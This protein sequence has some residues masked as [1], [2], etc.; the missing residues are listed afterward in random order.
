MM[1]CKDMIDVLTPETR[2]FQP[3]HLDV[4][5]RAEQVRSTLPKSDLCLPKFDLSDI[6]FKLQLAPPEGVGWTA[7]YAEYVEVWYRRY[8]YLT[9]KYPDNILVPNGPIDVFWHYHILDTQKYAEDCWNFF[10]RFLH[11]FPY[12]GLK[13]DSADRDRSF[14][15]SNVLY[16]KEFGKDCT[17]M[18]A[19]AQSCTGGGS[20][21]G[22]SQGCRGG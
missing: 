10:G 19:E 12:Y 17:E 13:G 9:K 5:G 15:E 11:H 2:R 20:G 16:R 7:E 8:L 3:P 18:S 22:C 4:I 21:T 1:S 14:V 6:R